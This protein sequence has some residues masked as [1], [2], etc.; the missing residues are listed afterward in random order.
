[1][2]KVVAFEAALQ[3]FANASHKADL[4]AINA[5]PVLKKHADTLKKIVENFAKN[6]SY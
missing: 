3:G 6:G 5:D 1:V 2:N 4:D